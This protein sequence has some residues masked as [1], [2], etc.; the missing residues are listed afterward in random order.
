MLMTLIDAGLLTGICDGLFSSVLA[1]FFYRSTVT[2]LFQGV[3]AT[4]L[5]QKALDGGT[6]AALVGVAMHFGV[7]FAWSAVLLLAATNSA[8]IRRVLISPFG[9]LRVAV[10]YGPLV[11][12]VMSLAIIPLLVH[13]PP[14]INQR[15]WVQFIG[16]SFFVGL[17]IAATV[18]SGLE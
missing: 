11:W 16:H 5:G 9:A 3:A 7:A 17:P 6:R 15:W 8:W 1:A 2:R 18:R 12:V 10:V 13:R 4:V 14:A